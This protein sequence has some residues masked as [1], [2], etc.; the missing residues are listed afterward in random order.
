MNIFL[1]ILGALTAGLNYYRANL[2]ALL[3][4]VSSDGLDGTDGMYILGEHDKYV[5]KVTLELTAQ[6]YPKVR[7]VSV[8]GANHFPHENNPKATN[9]LL[10]A[11][12]GTSPHDCPIEPFE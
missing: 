11:F 1:L 7:V 3:T 2:G 12:L 4:G 9:D 5:S 10:R 8:P 6:D